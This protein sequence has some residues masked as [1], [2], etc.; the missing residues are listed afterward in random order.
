MH[1]TKHVI[2]SVALAVAIVGT[3]AAPAAMADQPRLS[4]P[5]VA[6]IDRHMPITANVDALD[7]HQP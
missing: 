3:A 5:H 6:P 7:R 2:A 4:S 1:R